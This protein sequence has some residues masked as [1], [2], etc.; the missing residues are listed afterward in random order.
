MATSVSV[1]GIFGNIPVF[2]ITS[3]NVYVCVCICA[4]VRACVHECMDQ[5]SLTPSLF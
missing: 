5:S 1:H 4:C 3:N 2:N